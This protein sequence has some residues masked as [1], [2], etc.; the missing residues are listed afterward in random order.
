MKKTVF[1]LLVLMLAGPVMAEN[2]VITVV[3]E[4]NDIAAIKYTSDV[5]VR[6]FALDVNVTGASVVDVNQYFEGDCNATKKGFGI[7]LDTISGIDINDAGVVQVWGSPVAN[8]NSPGA[9]GTGIGKSRVILG[10][11]ALYEKGNQPALS[12][13]ICKFRVDGACTVCVTEEEEFRAGVVLEDGNGTTPNLT[14]ACGV[15]ISQE[16]CYVGEADEDEWIAVGR[17]KCWCYPRQCHGDADGYQV[18]ASKTTPAH[19][20]GDPDLNVLA[21]AWKKPLNEVKDVNDAQGFYL[22]CADF[23]H[24]EVAASK[25][26]PAH[27][28]GDPDLNILSSY[29]KANPEAPADCDPGSETP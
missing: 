28:V 19:W 17:P 15:G 6:A 23:D 2:V 16:D 20:V 5:N 29:W 18:A 24:T 11:G 1:V 9:T 3:D 4:G 7:F 13:T 27:R 22:A 26:T 12:G 14:G 8:A 25:T 10:M 21:T